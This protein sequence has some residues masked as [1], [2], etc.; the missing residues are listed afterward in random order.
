MTLKLRP[1]HLLCILTYAG[2][3]YSQ[4]FVENFNAIVDRIVSGEHIRIVAGPDDICSPL[5]DDGE[6]HC[7]NSSVIERDRLATEALSE[8]LGIPLGPGASI[9]LGVGQIEKMRQ[10]FA[11]GENRSACSGCEWHAL[12]SSIAERN[13]EQA[14]LE[15][16]D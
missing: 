9:S 16:S 7:R 11:S 1:H 10:S 2:K 5:L 14:R 12:C 6:A 13:F 15:L 3:G 4:S 8:L